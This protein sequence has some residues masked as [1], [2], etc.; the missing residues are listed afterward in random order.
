MGEFNVAFH[1]GVRREIPD[2]LY[3]A[4]KACVI[5]HYHGTREKLATEDIAS[6]QPCPQ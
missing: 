5:G 4:A 2:D 6:M 3:S 1:C